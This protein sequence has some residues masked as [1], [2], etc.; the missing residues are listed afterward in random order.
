MTTATPSRRLGGLLPWL[1]LGVLSVGVVGLARL[2]RA[3]GE[4]EGVT[5]FDY[6]GGLH[7][8]AN[9]PYSENPPAGG[10]HHPVWQNCGIYD[11]E[12][13]DEHVVHSME[14]GAVWITYLPGAVPDE[15]LE[16]LRSRF[17]GRRHIILSP[18]PSQTRPVMLTA[19]NR[20]LGVDD[21]D[22][23]RIGVFVARYTQGPQAPESGAPCDGGT[24]DTLG[25]LH[26]KRAPVPLKTSG[27]AT[28]PDGTNSTRPRNAAGGDTVPD[29]VG[30]NETLART[31][32]ETSGWVWRIE[33][34]DGESYILTQE[35][36]ERRINVTIEN[37][38][39]TAVRVG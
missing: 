25:T 7:T 22:D 19:W 4:I 13:R 28:D 26:T 36:N 31:L 5:A 24:G 2:G 17:Q 12:L 27:T 21:V 11:D 30:M 16:D 37:A 20:Q 34:R 23:A 10:A 32:T 39:V 35:R 15:R 14:H 6:I 38:T 8:E 33:A 3:D 9:V 29:V 1:L 18:K